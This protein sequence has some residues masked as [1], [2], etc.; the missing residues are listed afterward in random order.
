MIP[1]PLDGEWLWDETTESWIPLV[2]NKTGHP[3]IDLSLEK[4]QNDII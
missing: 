3:D 1:A 2:K 4:N